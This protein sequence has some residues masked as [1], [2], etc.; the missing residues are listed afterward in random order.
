MCVLVCIRVLLKGL[1]FHYTFHT[2]ITK[3]R[4]ALT[5][6]AF[7]QGACAMRMSVCVCMYVKTYHGCSE[8]CVLCC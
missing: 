3:M 2:V 1:G 7:H 8:W 4:P 6:G 5:E